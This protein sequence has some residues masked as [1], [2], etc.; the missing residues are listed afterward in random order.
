VCY[1]IGVKIVSRHTTDAYFIIPTDNSFETVPSPYEMVVDMSTGVDGM[2]QQALLVPLSV[3][4]VSMYESSRWRLS[5]KKLLRYCKKMRIKTLLMEGRLRCNVAEFEEGQRS[6]AF[7]GA[8]CPGLVSNPLQPVLQLREKIICGNNKESDANGKTSVV[9]NDMNTLIDTSIS[10]KDVVGCVKEDGQ[11][12]YKD[13]DD[14]DD[15]DEKEEDASGDSNVNGDGSDDD[16]D[17]DDHDD[18]DDDDDDSSDGSSDGSSDDDTVDDK[19]I[20]SSSTDFPGIQVAII[21]SFEER[22][23][24]LEELKLKKEVDQTPLHTECPST[25]TAQP[26]HIDNVSAAQAFRESLKRKR[27]GADATSSG[28][29]NGIRDG[30]ITPWSM[31]DCRERR[32]RLLKATQLQKS[33]QSLRM[34]SDA[35][36]NLSVGEQRHLSDVSVTFLGTGCATPSKHR[37]NSCIMIELPVATSGHFSVPFGNQRASAEK[38]ITLLDCG[39]GACAQLFQSVGGDLDRFDNHL[40]RISIIWISHHHADHVTGFPN[41][42]ENIQRARMRRSMKSPGSHPATPRPV[43]KP[44]LIIAPQSIIDYYS[45]A[46]NVSCLDELVSFLPI[47]ASMFAGCTRQAAEVTSGA[48]R[49]L[50]S[51]PVYHCKDSYGAVLQLSNGMK[52][53]YS[54][55]CRP[56]ESLIRAGMGC[57]ILI[58]EATFADD[59]AEDAVKKKHCTTSEAELVARKMNVTGVLV[60]THFSQRYPLYPDVYDLDS[61]EHNEEQSVPVNRTCLMSRKKEFAVA[62]DFLRFSY[63]THMP[64]LCDAT[65]AMVHVLRMVDSHKDTVCGKLV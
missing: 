60:L 11:N 12:D 26:A 40:L 32:G 48:L 29:V 21:R 55:D 17:D 28:D 65:K 57:D 63:P 5:E 18:D 9:S 14:D 8:V 6:I 42:A 41:L 51:V 56:S 16:D 45:Y 44:I 52:I 3:S 1:G 61:D 31:D 20:Q 30:T 58:H 36:A 64:T 34:F 59:L 24:L 35:A 43:Q 39:E 19:S 23:R 38:P 33:L 62:V 7:L 47:T 13:D 46:V 54:G 10:I 37:S 4:A 50:T 15:D 53:V 22:W 25:A 27:S 49:G 2:N